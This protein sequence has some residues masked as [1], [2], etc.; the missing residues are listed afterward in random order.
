MDNL[1][2]DVLISN[3]KK[4]V[5]EINVNLLFPELLS[6]GILSPEATDRILVRK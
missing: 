1:H 3:M 6:R 4:L 2:Q 5:N